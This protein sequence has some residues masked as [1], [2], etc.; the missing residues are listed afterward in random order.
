MTYREP[1]N[2][3]SWAGLDGATIQPSRR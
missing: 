1:T 3:F 2:K